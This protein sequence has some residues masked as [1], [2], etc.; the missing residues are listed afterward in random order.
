MTL[1]CRSACPCGAQWREGGRGGPRALVPAPAFL[2]RLRDRHLLIFHCHSFGVHGSVVVVV[3]DVKLVLGVDLRRLIVCLAAA[4]RALAGGA[5]REK[6]PVSIIYLCLA[7]PRAGFSRSG[8]AVHEG[9]RETGAGQA[10]AIPPGWRASLQ[11]S[12][13][14]PWIPAHAHARTPSAG[15]AS[16]PYATAGRQAARAVLCSAQQ[17]PAARPGAPCIARPRRAPA[18]LAPAAALAP[19]AQQQYRHRDVRARTSASVTASVLTPTPRSPFLLAR[20]AKIAR[21]QSRSLKREG[22]VILASLHTRTLCE[23]DWKLS[24][25]WQQLCGWWQQRAVGV[26]CRLRL[27]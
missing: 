24:G 17:A 25:W 23:A 26:Q 4:A 15:D 21:T 1:A 16:L 9:R 18:A 12:R 19:T 14:P 8:A 10:A 11:Y 5:A 13:P 7:Q 22:L 2:G 27:M 6:V 3:V 20:R